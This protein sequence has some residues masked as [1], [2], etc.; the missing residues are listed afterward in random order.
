MSLSFLLRI[1]QRTLTPQPP[2]C[3]HYRHRSLIR[4]KFL[5][6]FPA[7]HIFAKHE[8]K[9]KFRYRLRSNDFHLIFSSDASS[10]S[11]S[12]RERY[13]SLRKDN[14]ARNHTG[15]C[16]PLPRVSY[17]FYEM[18]WRNNDTFTDGKQAM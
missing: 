15:A 12:E 6:Y 9:E 13:D 16:I 7:R 3:N 11:E 5:A 17:K 10:K 4:A 18:C 8:C 2:L 14:F 1:P